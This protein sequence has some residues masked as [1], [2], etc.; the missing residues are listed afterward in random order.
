MTP[1]EKTQ[2]TNIFNS[3]D[4]TQKLKL[5]TMTA[6]QK[7]QLAKDTLAANKEQ[8]AKNYAAQRQT[9]NNAMED[10]S[11]GRSGATDASVS[12]YMKSHKVN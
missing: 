9:T 1:E 11:R 5:A 7:A 12:D 8:F 4:P 10:L 3:S 6:D 2:I